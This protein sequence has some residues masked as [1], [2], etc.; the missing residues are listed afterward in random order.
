MIKTENPR[1]CVI[2]TLL[3][4]GLTANF[5]KKSLI[6]NSVTFGFECLIP[7]PYQA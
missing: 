7:K 4:K 2:T 6:K 3:N 1:S 5:F